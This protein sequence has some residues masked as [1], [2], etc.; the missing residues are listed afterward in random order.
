[1]GQ[2][3]RSIT[4]NMGRGRPVGEDNEQGRRCPLDWDGPAG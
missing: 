1:M 2:A 4:M 3:A